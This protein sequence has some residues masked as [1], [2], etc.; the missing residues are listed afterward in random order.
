[1]LAHCYI[2]EEIL[3]KYFILQDVANLNSVLDHFLKFYHLFISWGV[4]YTLHSESMWRLAESFQELV[5]SYHRGPRIKPR[6]SELVAD[7]SFLSTILPALGKY[8]DFKIVNDDNALHIY[9]IQNG[10]SMIRTILE[11][12]GILF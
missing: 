1:M 10:R 9:I 11:I 5:L 8:F 2:T 3:A 7:N 12:I 4:Y 6:S